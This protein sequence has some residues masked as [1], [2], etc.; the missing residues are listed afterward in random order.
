LPATPPSGTISKNRDC[1][2]SIKTYIGA[3]EAA[4]DDG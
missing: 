3:V 1:T 2:I 4:H